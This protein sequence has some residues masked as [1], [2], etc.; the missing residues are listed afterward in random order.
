MNKIQFYFIYNRWERIRVIKIVVIFRLEKTVR[1]KEPAK[2]KSNQAKKIEKST[3]SKFN[4]KVERHLTEKAQ[5]CMLKRE[6]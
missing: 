2:Q 1:L 3:V 4:K 6:L 5:K